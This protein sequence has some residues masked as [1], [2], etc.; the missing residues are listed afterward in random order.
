[1]AALHYLGVLR[2]TFIRLLSTISSSVNQVLKPLWIHCGS[3]V[4][5]SEYRVSIAFGRRVYICI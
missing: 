2:L 1:M 4:L 5:F 3:L